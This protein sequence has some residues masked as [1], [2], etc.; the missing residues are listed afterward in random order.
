MSKP[1]IKIP[2]AIAAKSF[3]FMSFCFFL[4]LSKIVS[5]YII[6]AIFISWLLEGKFIY[7]FK[8]VFKEKRRLFLFSL[9]IVYLLYLIGLLYT[10]NFAYAGFDLQVKLSLFLFPLL[11]ATADYKYYTN[12]KIGDYI[13]LFGDGLLFASIICLG[14]AAYK[15]FFGDHD[16][17]NFLYAKLSGALN[18]HPSYMAMYLNFAIM[19]V[20][21]MMFSE[22]YYVSKQVSII[23]IVLFSIV[24]IMLSSKA[25]ILSMILTYMIFI[26][27]LIIKLKKVKLGLIMILTVIVSCVGVFTLVPS[28]YNRLKQGFD[29]A[30]KNKK[31][32]KDE[33]ES[34]SDRI[35][36]WNASSEIIKDNFWIGV[37]TGDV[38]DKLLEKYKEKNYMYAYERKLNSH[39]QFLQTFITLGVFGFVALLASLIIPL[40]FA[41]KRN[42]LVHVFFLIIFIVNILVE[43]MLENQAGVVFYAFFASFLLMVSFKRTITDR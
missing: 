3:F 38:K 1:E 21:T 17:S 27:Y 19:T 34:T 36:I 35:L 18:F 15:Y 2:F 29:V 33:G 12:E 32:L 43:S 13:N 5:S 39:N 24:I 42:N 11:F 7:R 10:K 23:K 4:P 37:G 9:S 31:D 16:S 28:A 22:I 6:A 20:L 8:L 30:S 26:V 41:I 40:I 25:G 14:V